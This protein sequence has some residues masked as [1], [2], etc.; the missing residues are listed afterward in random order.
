MVMREWGKGDAIEQ[1]CRLYLP[2]PFGVNT[3]LPLP[4]RCLRD[5][6]NLV[7]E[8]DLLDIILHSNLQCHTAYH[9]V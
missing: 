4:P 7:C 6:S 8:V 9:A 3:F 5:P 2:L 1:H